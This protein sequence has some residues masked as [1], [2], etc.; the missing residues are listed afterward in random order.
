MTKKYNNTPKWIYLPILLCSTTAI[1]TGQSASQQVNNGAH[2]VN[3]ANYQYVGG[4][5]RIGVGVDTEF[6]GTADV[7]HVFSESENSA[8][9]GDAW[10]GFDINGDNKGVNAGGARLNHHWVSRDDSGRAT[11]VNKVFGAYD[12]NS[13]GDDKATVGYGQEGDI[14]FWEGYVGKSLSDK[15]KTGT[16]G[17]KYGKDIYTK[18]FDYNVGGQVGTFLPGS[19][20]R[21]RGGVDY[22][23]DKLH[24]ANE[25]KPTQ[26]TVS[27]G[28]EKFFKDTPHSV[29]LDVAS[30]KSEG[31]YGSKNSNTRANLSYH[32]DFAGAD[33]YQSDRKY[34]RVRV[35][36]PG[37]AVTQTR[38]VKKA[39]KVPYRTAYQQP[40]KQA[41]KQAYKQPYQKAYKQAY[42][43]PVRVKVCKLVK[44]TVELGSD[45]FFKPNS[46]H[47]L[48]SAKGRLDA[49]I[50]QMR[51]TGYKGNIRVTGNTCDIGTTRH[52]Q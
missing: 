17:G 48:N 35:E 18:A 37:Q 21:V 13:E 25:D 20:L 50:A 12:R 43:Q 49:V 14:G 7:S 10:V 28:V 31:G 51:R 23:W 52:N 40:Y 11:R 34:K 26:M 6:N 46:S 38:T 5:T 19:N 36:M 1:A 4:K 45:T 27:A 8:T 2:E 29:S 41:Y 47:L 16:T 33:A 44:S 30:S 39:V 24:A 3:S 42:K 32:Y 22:A 9:S 15:R